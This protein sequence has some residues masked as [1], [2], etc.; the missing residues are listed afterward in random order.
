MRATRQ[1][2]LTRN[3]RL[4][5][6]RMP[7]LRFWR[8]RT[9]HGPCVRPAKLLH[10]RGAAP[11]PVD[12]APLQGALVLDVGSCTTRAGY[13]GEDTP[14]ASFPTVVCTAEDKPASSKGKGKVRTRSGA[15]SAHASA[16]ALRLS[17]GGQWRA[18]T[19]RT[20]ARGERRAWRCAGRAVAAAPCW[21]ACAIQASLPLQG[22]ARGL[23]QGCGTLC[24]RSFGC[25][26]V[27]GTL[28]L[29]S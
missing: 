3:R 26:G 6:T 14:K 5:L 27:S 13:A 25:V 29:R 10:V 8:S 2:P 15:C 18:A 9:R 1:P 19:A 22:L 12:R 24:V 28:A 21:P 4:A 17:R 20:H 23:F 7:S 11:S 16:R